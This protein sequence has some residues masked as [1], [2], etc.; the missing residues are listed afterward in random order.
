MM[1]ARGFFENQTCH[2][3]S[4]V[5]GKVDVRE[6]NWAVAALWNFQRRKRSNQ[7]IRFLVMQRQ[8]L[9]FAT[10]AALM[11][12]GLWNSGFAVAHGAGN[13]S[14]A[15]HGAGSHHGGK[16]HARRGRGPGE[17]GSGA[18]GYR[19]GVSG[20]WSIPGYGVYFAS[21]PSYCKLIYWDGEPYYY[22]DDLYYEWSGTVGGYQQVQP[23]AGLK[24]EIDSQASDTQLFVF[25]NA[26][27][28]NEQLERDRA[29]CHRWAVQQVGFDPDAAAPHTKASSSLAVKRGDYLRAD[30]AC[31]EARDYSVE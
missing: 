22:A 7:I 31:L 17:R 1:Q 28:T 26:D 10:L 27:Q 5:G 19:G 23:P 13:S 2:R 4:I 25:P 20:G 29:A 21:I 11:C 14:S 15:G 18:C 3:A 16:G 12:M 6:A 30:A 9:R 8:P 24:A